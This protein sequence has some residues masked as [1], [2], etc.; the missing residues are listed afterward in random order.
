MPEIGLIAQHSNQI[1]KQSST[2]K[3][4]KRTLPIEGQIRLRLCDVR[5]HNIDF[6]FTHWNS[7]NYTHNVTLKSD[8]GFYSI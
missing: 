5:T 8:I 2:C 4:D 7:G 1:E 6:V 3:L